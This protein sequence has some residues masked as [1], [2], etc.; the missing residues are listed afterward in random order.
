MIQMNEAIEMHVCKL[1]MVLEKLKFDKMV[2]MSVLKEKPEIINLTYNTINNW[3]M[4]SVH[5]SSYGCIWKLLSNEPFHIVR[6]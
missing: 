6:R 2:S 4:V 1:S 3:F 5:P